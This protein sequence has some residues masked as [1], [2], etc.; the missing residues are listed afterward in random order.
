MQIGGSTYDS[1]LGSG[2]RKDRPDPPKEWTLV[3]I[4]GNDDV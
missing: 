1:I 3:K 4:H 2:A